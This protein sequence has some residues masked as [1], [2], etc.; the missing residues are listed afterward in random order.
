MALA[1]CPLHTRPRLIL[2]N[3]S[4]RGKS[5]T[6]FLLRSISTRQ[7]CLGGDLSLFGASP[8]ALGSLVHESAAISGSQLRSASALA[9]LP[10]VGEPFV[11]V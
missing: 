3:H 7:R 4:I 6:A 1:V 2:C 5:G 11:L 8:S 10:A 9:H